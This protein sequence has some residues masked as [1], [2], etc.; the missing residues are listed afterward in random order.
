MKIKTIAINENNRGKGLVHRATEELDYNNDTTFALYLPQCELS[1]VSRVG[2]V[3][4]KFLDYI[5][6]NPDKKIGILVDVEGMIALHD[7]IIEAV[8][9]LNNTNVSLVFI[10]EDCYEKR[11]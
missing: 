9:E 7:R 5:E 4:P 11:K 1:D 2:I 6:N 3:G 10:M 8:S